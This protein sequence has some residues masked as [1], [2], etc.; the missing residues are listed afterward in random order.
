MSRRRGRRIALAAGA[1]AAVV[2]AGT[3]SMASAGTPLPLP[4][5]PP[6]PTLSD[7]A[8]YTPPSPL[9][10]GAPGDVVKTEPVAL[11]LYPEARAT[12]IM[13]LSRNI[14]GETVPVT[15]VLLT[16][17]GQGAGD[18]NPVVVHTPGTRGLGDHCA[19]SKQADVATINPPSAD[20]ATLEYHQ[21]LLRGVSVVLTDYLGQGTPGLPEYLV[22][23]SEGYNG[24]DA[25][26]AAQRVEGSGLSTDSPVGVSG[27]SQGGQ[28]AAWAAELQPKYA[29]EL[30]LR[31]VLAGGVPT[32]MLAQVNHLSGNPTAGPGFAVAA[33][34]GLNEAYPDL[35]L[36]SRLT[37]QGGELIKRAEESCY[38]EG[39][40]LS[41]TVSVG[42]VTQPDVLTDPEWQ[43]AFR[44]S[45]L[46]TRAPGA[47]AY[48][49]HGTS[50]TIV[51]FVL[52]RQLYTSWCEQDADVTFERIPGLEHVGLAAVGTPAGVS[53]L[54]DRLEGEPAEP[55][56]RETGLF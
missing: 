23:A 46:G 3:T 25:A 31:G 7:G 49:Y 41:G 6:A 16:P 20:Y 5:I 11:S 21:F 24:L 29:P 18:D 53:W 22:G 38:G 33:L 14:R 39:A 17:L 30:D 1:V 15:G 48:I 43:D 47:P 52:G 44:T 13:Y 35:D 19:P 4:P 37:P 9:P 40:A 34:V 2:L 10:E 26:R 45:L 50:D 55:G 54:T 51:P 27:F 56:C 36:E 32:D 28:A 12:R 8:F 42:D